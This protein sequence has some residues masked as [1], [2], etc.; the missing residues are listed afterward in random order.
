MTPTIIAKFTYLRSKKY[1]EL[2]RTIPCQNCFTDDGTVA[3]SHSNQSKHGHGRGIKA[4]DE[5]CASLC[6][7]C[8]YEVDQGKLYTREQKVE[9]W[10]QAHERTR[11]IFKKLGHLIKG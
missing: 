11:A 9:I 6:S 10:N 7:K 1:R 5:Y 8:H 3:A 2:C 4:S